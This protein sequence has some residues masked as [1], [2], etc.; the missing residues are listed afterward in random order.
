MITRLFTKK[1]VE[2]L[3]QEANLEDGEGL[4]RTLGVVNLTTLGIG[5][6]IGAG[7][8]VV[9][10]QVTASYTG[11]AIII[12]FILAAIGCAF[13]GLCYAEF[14]AMIPV[15][16]SAYTYTYAT[17]GEFVAWIIGWNLILEY[18][19][20]VAT[21]AVGWSGYVVSVIK[22]IGIII[23]PGL[24]NESLNLPAMFVVTLMM[25]LQ[26]VG[27]HESTK[28]NNFI[29]VV[30]TTV[31]LLFIF[32]GLSYIDRQ[33]W[34][35]FIPENTGEFGE[36]GW[37]GILRGAGIIFFTYIGFDAVSCAAQ[38][39]RN[40]QQ[41]MPI[42]ILGS[43]SIAT[44]L[45]I[46]TALVLTGIVPYPQ[47]NVPDSIALAV[48][49]VGAEL[50]WLSPLIKIGA[51]A[52]MS[53]VIL[54][55]LLGQSRILYALA[56][57]GL[58]PAKIAAI[59]P[60]FKTPYVAIILSG[61]VAIFLAGLLPISLL[62]EL[63]SIGTLMAF[64]IVCIG[65]LI[66]RQTQPDLH[67]PFKTPLVPLVPVLGVLICGVQMLSLSGATWLRLVVWVVIGLVIYLTYS[68]KNSKLNI[69]EK[70]QL[71]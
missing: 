11:P 12:S 44:V 53:S 27:V 20:A 40:P 30:K 54:V 22:D 10:G 61:I 15:A 28:F 31:I 67:R 6:I 62:A 3:I 58:L 55:L 60:K 69:L 49:A 23:P 66:L 46:C 63:V 4:Q 43:L 8:F 1:S 64:G 21:V 14:A 57:D 2:S 35:P 70:N 48:D 38:E 9:T 45:Y 52:G 51:I 5:A 56:T 13:C 7:I 71:E 36:F 16:G 50:R 42:A 17:L 19:F 25:I 65:V 32:F 24:A 41:D 29:V 18:T 47:L 33:N 34:I 37:S 59:H 39:A 68:R 26:V